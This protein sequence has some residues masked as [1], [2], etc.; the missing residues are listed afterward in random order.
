MTKSKFWGEEVVTSNLKELYAPQKIRPF[1]INTEG[2]DNLALS[3]T[4]TFVIPK[5]G[6]FKVKFEGFFRVA[7]EK[8]TS[9]DWANGDVY[10]NMIEINLK[11]AS[12]E[13]G[14]ISVKINPDYVSA[15]QVFSSGNAAAAGQCRIATS[16][17]F[18]APSMNSTLFNKEPILLMNNAIKSVP[19][20]E[21]PNGTAHIYYIP[22]FDTKDPNGKP[23][24]YLTS[25]R[26]TV[27]TYLTK[28]DVTKLRARK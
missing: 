16:V 13:L 28:E 1:S 4:D 9:K 22:L 25:L 19:P 14:N 24:A 7:R 12:K 21:D 15:G 27:G 20:V 2:I 23:V 18:E 17:M 6:K 8:A 3:S 11:G 26:Y 5:R 10:V